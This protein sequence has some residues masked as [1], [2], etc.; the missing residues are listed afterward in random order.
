M[1]AVERMEDGCDLCPHHV[2]VELKDGGPY[3]WRRYCGL[4]NFNI[5]TASYEV[6]ITSHNKKKYVRENV[7]IDSCE[8]GRPNRCPL[9]KNESK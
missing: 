2:E 8:Y 3:G 4:A 6:K 1:K 5:D 7:G 9:L